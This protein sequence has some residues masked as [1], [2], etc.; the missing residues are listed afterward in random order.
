MIVRYL[1]FLPTRVFRAFAFLAPAFLAPAFLAPA[2]L[3]LAFLALAALG[4]GV[5]PAAAQEAPAPAVKVTDPA[6][7]SATNTVEDPAAE[8]EKVLEWKDYKVKGYSL[9]AYGGS[10]SGAMYLDL[11]ALD[12]KTVLTPGAGDI[13]AYDGGIVAESIDPPGSI[14]RYTAAQKEIE[15]G[16]MFGGSVGIYVADDFHVDLVGSYMSGRAVTTMLYNP[17]PEVGTSTWNRVEVDEDAGFRA[18]KGGLSLMYDARPATVFGVTPVIGFGLGG[19]IN[20]YSE[21]EDKTALYLEGN[22]GFSVQPMDN[23]KVIGRADLSVFA[24]DVDELGYSN[25]VGYRNLSLGVAWF[26]DTVPAEAR[27]KHE[28]E[29]RKKR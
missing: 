29:A 23:L 7:K 12:P 11:P 1:V 22:F 14:R 24:Y 26:L 3:A 17:D 10:F 2:F 16:N 21:L 13:L 4:T 9:S 15:P 18:Y 28:A 27:A 25:M 5:A 20:R 19:V 6:T 8:I